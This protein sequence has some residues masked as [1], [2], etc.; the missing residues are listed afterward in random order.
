[1]FVLSKGKS[2]GKIVNSLDTN[3]VVISTTYYSVEECSQGRHY[4]ENPHI[5]FLL[6]GE[7]IESRNN[8]SYQRKTGDIY[9]YYAGEVHASISRKDISKHT[10]I[11]FGKT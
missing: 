3:G 2:T 5:C 4:H 11:E 7:D 9:F 8:L 6:Q 1:M 10:N